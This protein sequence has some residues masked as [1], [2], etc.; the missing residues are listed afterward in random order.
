MVRVEKV[1]LWSKKQTTELVFPI[2]A[3]FFQLLFGYKNKTQKSSTGNQKEI[4]RNGKPN[5]GLFFI[6]Q[7]YND[8]ILAIQ[9]IFGDYLITLAEWK[10]H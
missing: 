1:Y 3:E 8:S 6:K 9:K 4:A 5:F 7:R 2:L 10:R